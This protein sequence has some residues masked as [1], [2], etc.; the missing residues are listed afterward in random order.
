MARVVVIG[1]GILGLATAYNLARRGVKDVLVV[2][3]NIA[4]RR[5]VVP[6]ARNDD[7]DM[8]A[9]TSGLKAGERVI[10]TAGVEI[11]DGAKVTESREK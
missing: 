2:D 7:T 4:H 9:V 10:V 3:G 5:V 6:G 1:A 11:A 8:V